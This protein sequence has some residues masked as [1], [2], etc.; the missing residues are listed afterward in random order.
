MRICLR[1]HPKKTNTF[2]KKPLSRAK[3]GK[4][5]TYYKHDPSS[6]HFP[7][8]TFLSLLLSQVAQEPVI[9]ADVM[10]LLPLDGPTENDGQNE[11]GRLPSCCCHQIQ[12]SAKEGN[13]VG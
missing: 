8:I 13:H 7:N 11:N 5:Q 6:K 4:N 1:K 9:G 10:S 12:Q 2:T 3:N